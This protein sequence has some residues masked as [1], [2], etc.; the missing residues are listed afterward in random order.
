MLQALHASRAKLDYY[1][2][3]TDTIRGDLY[4]V[5]TMLAP[6]NKFKFF[7]TKDWDN[8]WRIRYRKSFND[9]LIPYQERLTGRQ[10]S[11]V[12]QGSFR[13]G[14]RLGLLLNKR[15][16]QSTEPKDE[17]QGYLDTGTLFTFLTDR[18][19]IFSRSSRLLTS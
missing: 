5:C 9:F 6:E 19:L 12:S 13:K 2:S 3:M 16:P 8:E 15:K 14:S 7:Q 4:V 11:P 17:I 10:S 18:V 1:Y